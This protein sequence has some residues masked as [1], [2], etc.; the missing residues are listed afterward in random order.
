VICELMGTHFVGQEARRAGGFGKLM[1]SQFASE[2]EAIISGTIALEG[3]L[4]ATEP[5]PPIARNLT[6]A[7][8]R[9]VIISDTRIDARFVQW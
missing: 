1:C 5:P 3:E 7:G 2:L 4:P 9:A 8:Q 6:I